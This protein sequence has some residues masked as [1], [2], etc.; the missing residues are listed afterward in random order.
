MKAE[1]GHH[2]RRGGT[3]TASLTGPLAYDAETSEPTWPAPLHVNGKRRRLDGDPTMTLL[4]WLREHEGLRGAKLGCG[5]GECGACTVL[6]DGRPVLSCLTPLGQVAGRAVTTVEGVAETVEGAEIMAALEREDAVQCGFCTPGVVMSLVSFGRSPDAAGPG[7]SPNGDHP[8][9]PSGPGP[10][11]DRVPCAQAALAGNLCR[12]TGYR[13]L[14]AAALQVPVR[15]AVQPRAWGARVTHARF[16]RPTDLDEALA[17]RAATDLRVVAGGTD[18][19]VGHAM[20]SEASGLLDLS[21]VEELAAIVDEGRS[22]RI[23]ATATFYDIARSALVRR[24]CAPLPAAALEVG[25]TQVQHQGTLGGNLANASPAADS[26]PALAVLGARVELRSSTGARIVP[27]EEFVLG[28]RL[29]ALRP[30]ELIVAVH[31]DKAEELGGLIAF[32]IKTGA[33]R[34]QAISIA[35]LALRGRWDAGSLYDLS[36]SFG[37]LAPAVR[38][39]PRAAE[40]LSSGPLD[41]ARVRAGASLADVDPISDVRGSREYRLRLVEG[42]LARGLIDAGVLHLG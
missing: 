14:V 11:S 24:W 36:L 25:A 3:T 37:A 40:A 26:F 12:C 5:E 23:G 17:V 42:L 7:G 21:G 15:T 8:G 20:A 2:L 30:D 4:E 38:C 16:R 34:A 13:P 35:S 6:L 33:R 32:F 31:V 28:P 10:S 27:F 29:T 22:V 18:L 41:Y 39:S 1:A 19:Y 9:T